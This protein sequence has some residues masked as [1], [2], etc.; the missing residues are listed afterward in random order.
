[1]AQEESDRRAGTWMRVRLGGERPAVLAR[2]YGYRDGSGVLRVVQRLDA[3]AEKG[4]SLR[5]KLDDTRRPVQMSIVE[6]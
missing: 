2:E 4:R 6:T 3:A 5:V 1:M